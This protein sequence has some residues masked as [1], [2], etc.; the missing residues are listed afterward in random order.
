MGGKPIDVVSRL[1]C[2]VIRSG[3]SLRF[4]GK[5][6]RSGKAGQAAKPANPAKPGG[7]NSAAMPRKY[8]TIQNLSIAFKPNDLGH[9]ISQSSLE[10]L[11]RVDRRK[12]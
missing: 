6:G 8:L 3:R 11:L 9:F 4:P 10:I 7:S 12:L 1:A 2:V 5:T